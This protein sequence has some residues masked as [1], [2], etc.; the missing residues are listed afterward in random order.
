MDGRRNRL[1]LEII[2]GKGILL[3]CRWWSSWAFFSSKTVWKAQSLANLFIFFFPIEFLE[4]I[5]CETNRY[6]NNEDRVC[7][8]AWCVDDDD[9]I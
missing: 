2:M 5:T 3:C 6:G 1:S 7:P 9:G 4:T 8:V